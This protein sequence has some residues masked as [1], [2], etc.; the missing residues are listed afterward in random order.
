MLEKN[1]II[2]AH[3]SI[4]FVLDYK[5]IGD[6]IITVLSKYGAFE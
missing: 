5:I 1:F 4:K 2:I 3:P 6:E